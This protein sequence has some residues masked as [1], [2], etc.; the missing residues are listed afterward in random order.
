MNTSLTGRKLELLQS[1][2]SYP[3]MR[4]KTSFDDHYDLY[5]C[6]LPVFVKNSDE[7]TK[8]LNNYFSSKEN[9]NI[10]NFRFCD[11][12]SYLLNNLND[13]NGNAIK[14]FASHGNNLNLT[15]EVAFKLLKVSIEHP[16][17]PY[18][19]YKHTRTSVAA[20]DF[21]KELKQTDSWLGL[22]TDLWLTRDRIQRDSGLALFYSNYIQGGDY[23]DPKNQN[24]SLLGDC[25]VLP[26]HRSWLLE[27][28]DWRRADLNWFRMDKHNFKNG[29]LF[30]QYDSALPEHLRNNIKE[31]LGKNWDFFLKNIR[32][33]KFIVSFMLNSGEDYDKFINDYPYHSDIHHALKRRLQHGLKL[34][35]K[36]EEAYFNSE[37]N[38]LKTAAGFFGYTTA[39]LNPSFSKSANLWV[40]L[41]AY[42]LREVDT[43]SV[44][45]KKVLKRMI[46]RALTED[47]DTFVDPNYPYE[48]L[49]EIFD[50]HVRENPFI[51][52]TDRNLNGE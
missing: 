41:N 38:M 44:G 17:T 12:N 13:L 30:I 18:Y 37:E 22:G 9:L 51:P 20:F 35:P 36:L 50:I 33:E 16:D 49:K 3:Y 25:D 47:L 2:R 10:D 14:W 34:S 52:S 32:A 28:L 26:H 40:T 21:S 5:Y 27:N 19:D 7:F 23:L 42:D 31:I 1:Y 45:K 46:S 43:I 6:A 11:M 8:W 48:H 4:N 24:P 39:K 15:E 29:C